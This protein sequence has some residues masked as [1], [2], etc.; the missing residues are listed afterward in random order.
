MNL[1]V[2][3]PA[4]GL[5]SSEAESIAAICYCSLVAPES[6]TVDY[7]APA[8]HLVTQSLPTLH[9]PV[10]DVW[11]AGFDDIVRYLNQQGLDADEYLSDE[12]KADAVAYSTLVE[13]KAHDLTV[14][15]VVQHTH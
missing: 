13:R 12:A 2:D 1:C 4:F 7:A 3:P 15:H 11:V 8:S 10:G 14:C 9:D 6:F 5:P